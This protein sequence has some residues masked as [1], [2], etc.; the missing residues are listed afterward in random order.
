MEKNK[1]FTPIEENIKFSVLVPLYNTEV[2]YLKEMIDSVVSQT[3]TNWELCLA[4]GSTEGHEDVQK[5]CEEYAWNDKRI[6]YQKLEENLGISE[7]TNTCAKMATGEYIVLFDHDDLMNCMALYENARAIQAVDADV[8]YSD[9]D[10]VTE[11][12]EHVSPLFK[13]DWSRDLLYSQ[14]YVCH[15][16]VFKRALFEKIGGFRKEFDGSQDY[17]LMLRFSEETERIVHIPKLLYSWR[18][19]QTSTAKNADSKPYAHFA[20]LNALNDHLK[21]RY[22]DIA[23]AEQSEYTFVFEARFDLMSEDIK[24]SIIMP[25][26]DHYELSKNCIDSILA[27]TKHQNYEI[28]ILNN[29]SEKEETFKWFEEV[30][31]QD[32]RIKVVDASFEFNW[33]KL[34]NF[35]MKQA[36]GDVYVFLNND[37]EVI[38]EDWLDRLGENAL[39]DDIGVV[40]PLLL[41]EDNTI[42]H[43]GIVVGIGGW[44]D[45]VFRGQE[46][47]HYGSPYISPMLNRNVSA[48]TGACMVI[49][50][51]TIEKIGGFDES[52]LVCGSDVEICLRAYY[53]GLNN[54]YDAR[55][56]LYH[57]E[58]KSR[59]ASKVPEVDFKR[60][61]ECYTPFRENGDPFY[62][63]NLDLTGTMPKEVADK[64]DILNN[65]DY[66]NNLRFVVG[67]RITVSKLDPATIEAEQ[68]ET[69]VNRRKLGPE[70]MSIPEI[71]PIGARKTSYKRKRLNILSPSVDKK[72][73]FGGIATAIKFY[74]A[75]GKEL[76]CDMRI[77]VTDAAVDVSNMIE[78]F[79]YVV[80]DSSD[81]SDAKRQIV[82]FA[83]RYNKT[84]PVG[85]NDIFMATGWWTAYTIEEVIKWQAMTYNQNMKALVYM[86]QDYEPGFY[87]WSS[88]Y[89]MS[90]STY[91]L[92]VPTIAVVNSELLKEHL[93][94]F[95]YEFTSVYCFDPVLNE[96][97][98]EYVME[99]KDKYRRKKQ[100]LI[101]GRPS[102]ARNAFELIITSLKEWAVKYK[103]APKWTIVSAGEDFEDFELVNGIM[104]KSVGKLSLEEYGK[105]MLETSIGISLMVSPHPSY[106]PL[107]MSTF[108]VRTITNCYGG[109]DLRAFNNNII[110]LK[111]CSS[112][113]ICKRLSSLCDSYSE[114][115]NVILNEDY[116]G[117]SDPFGGV[118]EELAKEL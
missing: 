51:K 98:K 66:L 78:L 58:S 101:Y 22:G 5:V 20:G 41:F 107:E 37:I 28:I 72:H 9:E 40:G 15:L 46:P 82:G 80:V 99:N 70:D 13:P 56:R 86:I 103:D 47:V 97:L 18:E 50:K 69:P 52:F 54:I 110:S 26:K 55:T 38:S 35:G 44:A 89:L 31:K 62:N 59:D 7:N 112:S 29:N 4:D 68:K 116:V 81:D 36:S 10:H 60:S 67:E 61:Y 95:G 105:M 27:K 111:N 14:M 93:L 113:E 77:I 84:I 64:S 65:Y 49:S 34:N 114:K 42:Q 115:G 117:S 76:G 96:K 25:M 92:D 33:S 118:I 8:L 1:E 12:G 79:N 32:S 48:V 83:D 71:Q 11:T 24:V 102:V 75:L 87:A 106:P 90:E 63:L 6:K 94:S 108:G 45:H 39:R 17:D 43:A 91:R 85:E 104:V 57:L 16:F 21:R 23:H 88:R 2:K 73:V 19:T 3:Y 53:K 74:E 109:K 100:I 30:V